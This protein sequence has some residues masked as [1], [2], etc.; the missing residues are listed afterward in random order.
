LSEL[1]AAHEQS[2]ATI[3]PAK[4]A[5]LIKRLDA[6]LRPSRG[7]RPRTRQDGG[8]KPRPSDYR[9]TGSD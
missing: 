2:A 3:V 7:V 8:L 5:D 1:T 6:G 4:Y 9:S